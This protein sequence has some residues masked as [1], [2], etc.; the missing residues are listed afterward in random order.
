LIAEVVEG[1]TNAKLTMSCGTMSFSLLQWQSCITK[2]WQ[3]SFMIRE[4]KRP[5]KSETKPSQTPRIL[6]FGLEFVGRS[7]YEPL[8][9]PRKQGSNE[10]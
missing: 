3:C 10:I 7:G 8:L 9:F 4:S 6:I 2:T 1:P 5:R